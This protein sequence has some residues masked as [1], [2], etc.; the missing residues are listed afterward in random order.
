MKT[1]FALLIY[2]LAAALFDAPAAAQ[3]KGATVTRTTAG[4]AQVN[5]GFGVFLNKDSSIQV[6]WTTV[7][8]DFPADLEG[9]VGIGVDY[10]QDRVRGGY[11]YRTSF[12][13][14]VKRAA[15]RR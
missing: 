13:L 4:Y 15:G 14:D 7:H 10:N 12:T 3:S 6:E 11:R 5:L 8:T 9:H 1:L 2:I